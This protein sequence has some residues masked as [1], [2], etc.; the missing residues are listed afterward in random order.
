MVRV[1]YGHSAAVGKTV[2]V[3]GQLLKVTGVMEDLPGNSDI[4]FDGLISLAT[5]KPDAIGWV[6]TYVLL[7]NRSAMA[8]FQ[9]KLDDFADK[10]LN[11][12]LAKGNVAFHYKL[13]PLSSL[14]FSN[15]YVYDTPKGNRVSVDIFLTLGVLILVI[16]CT[17]SVNMMVVRSFS[18]SLEVTMQKIYGASR[19][20]LVIQQLLESLLIGII[21]VILSFLLLALLL[22]AFAAMV[23]R[24]MV[25]SDLLNRKIAVAVGAA[26]LVLA[27][28]GA[29]YSGLYLQRSRLA[30]L[31]RSKKGKGRSDRSRS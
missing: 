5:L 3:N 26:L 21:A 25:L 11:P 2:T 18:R 19:G 23:D 8:G 7:K 31:L 15:S 4:T 29:V 17:N 30:D 13:E 14:H 9:S 6:Y 27:M 16:A 12:Q 1:L 24:P 28:S 20:E 22:P 10:Y